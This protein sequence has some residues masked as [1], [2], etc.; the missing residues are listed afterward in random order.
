MSKAVEA[1]GYSIPVRV[2]ELPSR[3]MDCTECTQHVQHALAAVPGVESV[4]VFLTSEKAVV[5]LDPTGV[6][7]AGWRDTRSTRRST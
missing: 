5:R 4:E 3:G 7:L 1:A 2:I 6:P